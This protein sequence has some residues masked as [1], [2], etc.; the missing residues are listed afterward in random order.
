MTII[1]EKVKVIDDT[2]LLDPG[3]IY[4]T[5]TADSTETRIPED[6]EIQMGNGDIVEISKSVFQELVSKEPLLTVNVFDRDPWWTDSLGS[7][8]EYLPFNIGSTWFTTD[9]GKAK[10]LVSSDATITITF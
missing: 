4:L 7:I 8:S 5:I 6:G 2:D 10:V 9:N 1:I 3:E